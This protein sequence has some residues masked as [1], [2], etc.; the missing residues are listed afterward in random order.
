MT[1]EL[2]AVPAAAWAATW[3]KRLRGAVAATTV[4]QRGHVRGER[5]EPAQGLGERAYPVGWHARLDE[6]VP[7]VPLEDTG[8]ALRDGVRRLLECL[9]LIEGFGWRDALAGELHADAQEAGIP[10][11]H[12]GAVNGDEAH[13]DR[14]RD[15]ARGDLLAR[16]QLPELP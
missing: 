10:H 14:A 9:K 1:P 11:H 13:P 6:V 15:D 8:E 12:A 7:H 4:G 5:A 2:G 3:A 16:E